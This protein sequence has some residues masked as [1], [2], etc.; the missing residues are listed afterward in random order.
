[1][2]FI[3]P[4]ASEPNQV[5]GPRRR[6]NC[7]TVFILLNA[8]EGELLNCFFTLFFCTF[9]MFSHRVL[10]E[11]SCVGYISFLSLV[12]S[13]APF[14]SI[15]P[16]QV[17]CVFL[18][19]LACSSRTCDSPFYPLEAPDEEVMHSHGRRAFLVNGPFPFVS[20]SSLCEH[21]IAFPPDSYPFT[22]RPVSFLPGV[23]FC[24]ASYP[25][26]LVRA[27]PQLPGT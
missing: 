1:M 8:P 12:F 3:P 25:F 6:H 18:F 11:K 20:L 17:R 2:R 7:R 4:T 9:R 24:R 10:F 26:Y 21:V 14:F 15:L 27:L 16:A 5:N 23:R 22:L 13:S 19:I